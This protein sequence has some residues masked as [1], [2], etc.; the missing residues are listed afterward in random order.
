MLPNRNF[1]IHKERERER[2]SKFELGI[3]CWREEAIVEMFSYQNR[4]ICCRTEY[5]D[6]FAQCHHRFLSA[7]EWFTVILLFSCDS[8][9]ESCSWRREREWELT[10]FSI[11]NE[12]P[13]FAECTK[14]SD[15][16]AKI[17][18]QKFSLSLFLLANKK[19][20]RKT[21]T[22]QIDCIYLIFLW[23][24]FLRTRLFRR[25]KLNILL[26]IRGYK[27]MY[28]IDIFG[29]S[30]NNNNNNKARD[31]D[32]NTFSTVNHFAL[33]AIALCIETHF[34]REQNTQKPLHHFM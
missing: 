10:L 27:T 33:W 7:I 18:D 13:S 3:L 22:P 21:E 14:T 28:F 30:N 8:N 6:E 4:L 23:R 2:V 19:N 20:E 17:K 25:P 9:C 15:K 11:N 16:R 26:Q 34:K 24:I 1:S 32:R 29:V 31:R 12:R 5:I